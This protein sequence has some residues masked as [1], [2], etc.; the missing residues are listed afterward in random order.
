MTGSYYQPLPEILHL[1]F[2]KK[3]AR[4]LSKLSLK[5]SAL[6][7]PDAKGVAAVSKDFA[8]RLEHTLHTGQ[9]NLISAFAGGK[10]S[11]IEFSCMQ[12]PLPDPIP[13]SLPAMSKMLKDPIVLYLASR[14]QILLGLVGF[15]SFAFDIDNGGM[16]VRLVGNFKGGGQIALVDED[17][18]QDAELSSHAGVG[19]GLH[20]EPPY[21]C[22]VLSQAAHSPAP[23]ALILTARWNPKDEPTRLTPVRN[24]VEKLNSLDALALTSES[25]C[26]TRSDCFEK[27]ENYSAAANSILQ[28]DQQSDFTLR[29]SSYRY[30]LHHEACEPAQR[31]YRSFKRL[32]ES[33]TPHFFSLHSDSALLINN[34]QTL[35]A[36]EIIQ[37]NRRLLVRLFAYSPE[38]QPLILQEDPLVVRG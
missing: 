14:N 34:S 30:S 2:Q 27:D 26:F 3:Q 8:K 10:I 19:L 7:G 31:A 25:F 1:R 20:T 4:L 5:L 18:S 11:A 24:I 36:R 21:Y 6:G 33:A 17:E 28:F 12:S 38:A 32:V 22:S 9:R 29:Y 35:H 13:D 15:R 16:Q 37:D 23:S